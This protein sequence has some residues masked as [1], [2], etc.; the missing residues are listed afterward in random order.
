MGILNELN[1]PD[2]IQRENKA[3]SLDL[4][5]TFALSALTGLCAQMPESPHVIAERAYKIAEAMM[6]EKR[7]RAG[8]PSSF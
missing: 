8:L 6:M 1:M 7:R 2:K 5:D 3:A 4:L